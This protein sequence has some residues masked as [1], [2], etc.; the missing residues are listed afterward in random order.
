MA[1]G[2]WVRGMVP[3]SLNWSL[4]PGPPISAAES[5]SELATLGVVKAELAVGDVPEEEKLNMS[6]AMVSLLLVDLVVPS[7]EARREN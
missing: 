3:A 6:G 1:M 4:W 5:V 7:T 2:I